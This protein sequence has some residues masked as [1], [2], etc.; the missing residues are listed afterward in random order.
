MVFP[1]YAFLKLND[2]RAPE[3][4]ER[5]KSDSAQAIDRILKAVGKEHV[6]YDLDRQA[7][8]RDIADAYS[9]RDHEFDL[10]GGSESRQRL[11]ALR[12]MRDLSKKLIALLKADV[13]LDGMIGAVLAR[14]GIIM[15]G[16]PM[17]RPLTLVTFLEQL[18]RAA[19]EI[20][21]IQ[22][23]INKKWRGGHKHDPSLRGR[24]LNEKEWLA[25]VML[26]LLFEMHFLKRAG[27]SRDK[28]GRPSGP[29]ISFIAATMHELG[30]RYSPES[31]AKAYSLRA[32]LRKE[33]GRGDDVLTQIRR[34]V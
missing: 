15:P 5:V 31:I 11:E 34:Q 8:C 1:G 20:E 21:E 9:A 13:G 22:G 32:P 23:R 27:R 24:R 29:M 17:S 7:L 3:L 16:Y 6:P 25:G 30:L 14:A 26:P 2:P 18:H 28:A 33:R 10:L 19:G 12:R 4:T